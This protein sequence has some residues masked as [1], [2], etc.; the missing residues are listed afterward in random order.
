MGQT[1]AKLLYH[2]IFSTKKR[3]RLITAAIRDRLYPY[4][5]AIVR[6]LGGTALAI[7]GTEDHAHLLIELPASSSV[8]DVMRALKANSSKWIHES[9]SDEGVFAWQSGY[10]AFTVSESVAGKVAAYIQNQEEHHR[11]GCFED[12]LVSFLARHG[13][14]YDDRYLLD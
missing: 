9:F 11:K 13:I 14:E 7:G 6:N 12:E 2:V 4:M 5:A 1:H 3:R 8:A 10:A